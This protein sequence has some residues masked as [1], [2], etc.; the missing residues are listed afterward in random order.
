MLESVNPFVTVW[1]QGAQKVDDRRPHLQRTQQQE[2]GNM[3]R[4]KKKPWPAKARPPRRAGRKVQVGNQGVLKHNDKWRQSKLKKS[5]PEKAIKRSPRGK[6]Q[7]KLSMKQDHTPKEGKLHGKKVG[8]RLN[9]NLKLFPTF[10][11]ERVI[12]NLKRFF[13]NRFPRTVR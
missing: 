13:S 2:E 12:P 4:L 5:G 1:A 9:S 6:M 3:T 11:P 10:E 7:Q 8:L